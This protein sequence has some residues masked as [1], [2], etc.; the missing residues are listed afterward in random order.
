[1]TYF[2]VVALNSG[3]ESVPSSVVVAKRQAGRRA[4]I[5]IVNNFSRNARTQDEVVDLPING[6]GTHT[7]VTRVRLR[8]N[9]TF[10]YVVQ[11]GEAIEAFNPFLGVESA[12]DAAVAAGQINLENYSAVI[13]MSGEQSTVDSTF[14]AT[15]QPLVASYVSG[16]GKLF[17]SGS[18]IGWDLVANGH[19]STFFTNT[20][21]ATYVADDADTYDAVGASGAIFAGLSLSFD[22]GTAG[23]YDVDFP[24]TI[25]PATGSGATLAMNYLTS[26]S[27]GAAIQYAPVGAA[28]KVVLMAFPFETITTAANRNAVMAA[29]LNFFSINS[30]NLSTTPVA[31]D[32]TAAKDSGSSPTDNITNNNNSS[33]PKVL[34]FTVSG[35]IAAATVT[36]YAD[37]TAIGSAVANGSSTTIDTNGSFALSE[38]SH[39]I[40]ASQTEPFKLASNTTS[41]L[42]ISIDTIA[43]MVGPMTFNFETGQSL[44]YTFNETIASTFGPASI[45]VTNLSDPSNVGTASSYDGPTKKLT[46]TF[47]G[48]VLGDANYQATLNGATIT[49]V[50]GN[51]LANQSPTPFYFLMADANRD[52]GVNA[53]DF[54]LL[55]ANFGA[56]GRT[57]TQGNFNYDGVV[58]S[59]DFNL[60]ASSFG[61]SLAAPAGPLE[62]GPSDPAAEAASPGLF[63]AHRIITDD[64]LSSI[65]L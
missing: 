39:A 15:T 21:K 11:A 33:G 7:N 6:A 22:D 59:S 57:F 10:D 4:P 42:S 35:T 48:G 16:G 20:L 37:G 23:T 62:V 30:T 29:V 17:V 64:L 28:M 5:L 31:P 51:A 26:G 55:A 52:R 65:L 2:R 32:L 54:N 36:V 9:N 43:P 46:I 38:G 45:M 40:T 27:P 19:G 47:S 12:T 63:N 24:D 1:M 18:E 49:D 50:A 8:Y 56:N 61:K 3:G 44:Q 14:T 34:Q 41:G 13:W 60:L 53:M 25:K 58:N